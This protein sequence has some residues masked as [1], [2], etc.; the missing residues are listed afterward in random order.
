MIAHARTADRILRRVTRRLLLA[1]AALGLLTTTPLA[2]Q[3]RTD[4]IA[5]SNP[6]GIVIAMLNAGFNPELTTDRTGDP[7]IIARGTNANLFV[8]FFGCNPTTH[9]NCQWIRFQVAFDRAKPWS[10]AEA[11]NLTQELAFLSVRLD[12]EGD[13]FLHW[14]LVLG[15]G[16]PLPVFIKN[17]RA[18]EESITLAADIIY[19]EEKAEM[20]GQQP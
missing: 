9:D 6:P 14:D 1:L 18:F 15:E 20:L 2:A 10:P 8:L 16:I 13:P 4:T 11:I 12:E 17:L 3:E 5:A 19:A 7:M